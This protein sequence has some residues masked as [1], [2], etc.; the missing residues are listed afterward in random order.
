[1]PKSKRDKKVSLTKTNKKGLENK[2]KVIED[3]QGCAEQYPNVFLFSVENMRNSTLKFIRN[4]WNNS[5]FFFGKVSVMKLGLRNAEIAD[6]LCDM[7]EGQRGLLF[8]PN[9]KETVVD[10]FKEYSA[11]EFARSGFKAN[12]TVVLPEGPLS[13]FS[14]AI[15]PHLR[16]LGMPTKLERGIVTL[17]N[18]YTVC[19]KGQTLTPEQAKILK[20]VGRPLATFK[21]NIECCYTKEDGFEAIKMPKSDKKSS[22]RKP[23][24]A[25][26]KLNLKN[27]KTSKKT[28]S[29]SKEAAMM[30]II[31][32]SD[33]NE[34]DYDDSGSDE[35]MEAS[36]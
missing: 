34:E 1:M 25:K 32:A 15:E 17:M 2:Q 33:S 12:E 20:L 35:D 28:E 19:E 11:E 5:R 10:W 6:E 22:L 8:T 4:E 14:H 27:N 7:L 30:E 26:D 18:D 16:K 3:I 21:V 13:D 9:D 23:M 29:K 31:E 24:K 36:D